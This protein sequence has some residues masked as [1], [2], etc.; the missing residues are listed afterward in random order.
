MDTTKVR[1]VISQDIIDS[2]QSKTLEEHDIVQ[3]Y[4]A[5]QNTVLDP[6]KEKE[7]HAIYVHA[8]Q[9][10]MYYT[11]PDMEYKQYMNFVF[12]KLRTIHKPNDPMHDLME[13]YLNGTIITF[14]QIFELL[15]IAEMN[16]L[17]D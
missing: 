17:G 15:S 11:I 13:Q 12:R 5:L 8:K 9:I 14:Q 16:Y 3:Q 6:A 4:Y 1:N 10:I 7:N 2:C